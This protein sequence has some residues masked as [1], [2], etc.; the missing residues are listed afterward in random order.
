MEEI[1]RLAMFGRVEWEWEEKL[2]VTMRINTIHICMNLGL[3]RED[4][5]T[6]VIYDCKKICGII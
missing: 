1:T 6:C 3:E 5:A 2:M 4:Q